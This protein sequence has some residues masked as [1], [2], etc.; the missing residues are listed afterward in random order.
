[1]NLYL[2]RWDEPHWILEKDMREAGSIVS[3]IILLIAV[4]RI[5][6]VVLGFDILVTVAV[7]TKDSA[8]LSVI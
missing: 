6:E 5:N 7:V 4:E 8:S 1:M 2:A 3:A